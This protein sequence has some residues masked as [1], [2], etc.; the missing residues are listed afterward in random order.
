MQLNSIPSPTLDQL[1]PYPP[2][3]HD[4]WIG[5]VAPKEKGV[6]FG[7]PALKLDE[8]TTIPA[9]IAFGDERRL[10]LAE[11]VQVEVMGTAAEPAGS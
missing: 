9:G 6:V 2:R 7:K 1:R 3:H 4:Q 11:D 8:P 10:V 5:V